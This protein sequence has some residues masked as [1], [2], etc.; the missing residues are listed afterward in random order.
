M[1]SGLD[2]LKA[3]LGVQSFA[4]YCHSKSFLVAEKIA[5]GSREELIGQLNLLKKLH[6]H[7]DA[8][9]RIAPYFALGRTGDFALV[10][11]ILKGLRDPNIDVNVQALDAL[12]YL[13]RKPNG[14]GMTS[15]AAL[16]GRGKEMA[17]QNIAAR[18]ICIGP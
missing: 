12:R 8:Q 15:S 17:S 18:Q 7:P 11:D 10:P 1:L 5:L 13:S 2:F 4:K 14:F 3:W 6:K 9:N 16:K